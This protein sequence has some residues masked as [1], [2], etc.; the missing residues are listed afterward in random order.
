MYT[1]LNYF[2]KVTQLCTSHYN[3]VLEPFHGSSKIL[4]V[5]SFYLFN[6][7][8]EL[9][10]LTNCWVS[11]STAPL[12]SLNLQLISFLSILDSILYP[13]NSF[14]SQVKPLILG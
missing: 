11:N 8:P 2:N 7:V 12:C 1:E 9:H 13:L 5:C 4:S 3:L 10:P 14:T 6:S